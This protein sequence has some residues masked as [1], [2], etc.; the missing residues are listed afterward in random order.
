M[1]GTRI[2]SAIRKVCRFRGLNYMFTLDDSNMYLDS[3]TVGNRSRCLND[4]MDESKLN[5]AAWRG[6][7][8]SSTLVSPRSA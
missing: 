4:S 8:P 5:V 7:F 1:G 3:G 2:D 6:Y